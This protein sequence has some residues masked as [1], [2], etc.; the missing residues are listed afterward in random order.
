MNA[1]N[2]NAVRNYLNVLRSF[3]IH[4]PSLY[5]TLF[6]D[7]LSSADQKMAQNII[8]R[9]LKEADTMKTVLS[10]QF[11]GLYTIMNQF[12]KLLAITLRNNIIYSPGMLKE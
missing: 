3:Q 7:H 2:N 12:S 9:S 8:T 6:A 1:S 11:A 5:F 10:V 4:L